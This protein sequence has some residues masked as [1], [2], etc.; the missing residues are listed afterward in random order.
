VTLYRYITRR[1]TALYPIYYANEVASS[2]VGDADTYAI[3]RKLLDS[4]LTYF[5]Y[6]YAIG[7]FRYTFTGNFFR[8]VGYTRCEVLARR[9]DGLQVGSS[10]I[11]TIHGIAFRELGIVVRHPW[12][13]LRRCQYVDQACPTRRP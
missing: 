2:P 5:W 9:V 13:M 4:A 6:S 1:G 10:A 3:L 7:N 8:K 11:S 12:V